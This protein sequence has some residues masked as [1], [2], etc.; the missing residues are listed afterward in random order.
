MSRHSSPAT[1]SARSVSNY[2]IRRHITVN[3]AGSSATRTL[4]KDCYLVSVTEPPPLLLP[5]CCCHRRCCRRCH[6]ARRRMTRSIDAITSR[7]RRCTRR[8]SAKDHSCFHALNCWP[9][10]GA[11]M[12]VNAAR[13]SSVRLYPSLDRRPWA[14]SMLLG[15]KW[16]NKRRISGIHR[17]AGAVREIR[18]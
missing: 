7:Y 9:A 8:I 11:V 2:W 5:R 10:L 3:S 12:S 13:R 4:Q 1:A 16:T 18:F 14:Q 17:L 15:R 6:V